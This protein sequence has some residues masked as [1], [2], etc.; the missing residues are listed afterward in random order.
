MNKQ[1]VILAAG[2]GSRM[3][4]NVPKPMHLVKDTPMLDRVV[5]A[6]LNSTP[7]V[8]LVYSDA[9][10]PYLDKYPECQP[11]LQNEQLGT[12]HAVFCALEKIKKNSFVTII[13]ADH[14]FID[15]FII[16]QMFNAIEHTNYSCI[17]LAS[18]QEQDNAYGRIIR[19][20][21]DILE[22]VE[23]RN[24]S[25]EQRSIKL[26]NSALMSFAP[27][28]LHKFLFKIFEED[29][30]KASTNEY[31]LTRIVKILNENGHKVSYVINDNNK[32]SLGVNTKKELEIANQL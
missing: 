31:Y 20:D 9:L 12:A 19:N 25:E 21:S 6:S 15:T 3:I 2:R 1:V 28:I 18:L 17:T 26:C 7:D 22:I 29:K 8:I 4:S 14:P 23:Y 11:V 16:D 10:V 5:R 32:Y 13:Y 27:D 24:L 30:D